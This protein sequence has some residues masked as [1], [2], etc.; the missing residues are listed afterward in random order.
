MN[1]TPSIQRQYDELCEAIISSV[2]EIQEIEAGKKFTQTGMRLR[3]ITLEDVLMAIFQIDNSFVVDSGG[4][5]W[6]LNEDVAAK[7]NLGH[8]LAWHR[9][10]AP[11]TISFLHSFLCK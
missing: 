7:W 3:P 5:F 6:T 8:D 10:N 2:P 1:P 11:E 4:Q 9:D